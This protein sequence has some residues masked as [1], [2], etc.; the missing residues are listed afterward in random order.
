[1]K[2]NFSDFYY[3]S[4]Y[5]DEKLIKKTNDMIYSNNYKFYKGRTGYQEEDDRDSKTR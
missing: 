5:F 3:F 2:T 1:M 4:E